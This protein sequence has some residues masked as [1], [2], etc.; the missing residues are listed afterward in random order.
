MLILENLILKQKHVL[1]YTA[2][3]DEI[4]C[5]TLQNIPSG[6]TIFYERIGFYKVKLESTSTKHQILFLSHIN[7]P[8]RE[9]ISKIFVNENI[10]LENP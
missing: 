2:C 1:T 3:R 4:K 10:R 7:I 8:C 5:H 6:K 9:S